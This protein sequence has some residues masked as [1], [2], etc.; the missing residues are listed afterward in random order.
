MKV[1]TEFPSVFFGLFNI[2][3]KRL[4]I[5]HVFVVKYTSESRHKIIFP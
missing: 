2:N 3:L 1:F 5:F 4:K